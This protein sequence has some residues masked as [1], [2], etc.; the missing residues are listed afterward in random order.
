MNHKMSRFF[1]EDNSTKEKITLSMNYPI[2]KMLYK[3]NRKL[4]ALTDCSS[5]D[6]TPIL[7][8]LKNVNKIFGEAENIAQVSDFDLEDENKF[9]SEADLSFDSC[10]DD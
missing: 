8:K 6:S 9:N 1:K 3:N 7:K 10:K 2:Q 4:S 5:K